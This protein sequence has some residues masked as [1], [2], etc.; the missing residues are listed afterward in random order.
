MGVQRA[1]G[2]RAARLLVQRR[3]APAP[4]K[5][6][7]KKAA[8][9]AKKAAGSPTEAAT[10]A[11][12]GAAAAP[13][14]PAAAGPATEGLAPASPAPAKAV[15]PVKKGGVP[16][17]KAAKKAGAAKKAAATMTAPK[18][19][20][21]KS[22]KSRSRGGGEGAKATAQSAEMAAVK[23]KARQRGQAMKSTPSGAA[24]AK[25]TQAA[26]QGPANE[27][28]A[29]AK[30]AQVGD[31]A[32]AP[33]GTFDKAAFIAAVEAAIRKSTPKNLEQADDFADS[34]KMNSVKGEV[35]GKVASGTDSAEGG[36]DDAA[37]AQPDQGRGTA[38][39]VTPEPPRK[40]AARPK[41]IGA[42][43][44]MPRKLPPAATDLSKPKK[45]TDAAMAGAGVT[46]EQLEQSNEP[47]FTGALEAKKEGEQHSATAPG[48]VRAA[49]QKTIA[50]AKAGASGDEKAALSSML[51]SRQGA[52]QAVTGLKSGGKGKDEAARK[53]VSDKIEAIY[54]A[55]QAETTAILDG[56]DA[57][58][59]AEF[60]S[61][62]AKAR[63][64][65]TRQHKTE[66]QAWKDKRY[67]GLRGKARWLKDKL[68]GVP[69]AAMRIFDRARETYLRHLRGTVA[70]IADIV[71]NE[72]TR[73]KKRIADGRQEIND[74]V[75]TLPENLQ[76]QG[77]E[78]AEGVQGR[79]DELSSQV[80]AKQGELVQ[81]VAKRFVDARGEIDAKV[82]E[83]KAAN[84]GL[85][86]R[87]KA[88]I[89]AV[90]ATIKKLKDALIGALKKGADAIGM[91]I[92]AP[93]KFLGNLI[94]AFKGGLKRFTDNI[95]KHLKNGLF[96]WLTGALGPA[97]IK[98]PE[99]FDLKGIIDLV[100]QVLGLTWANIKGRIVKKL[101]GGA[102]KAMGYIES[103]VGIV[104]QLIAQGP[105]ALWNLIASK[106]T[107]LWDMVV[108]KIKDFVLTK[109]IMQGIQWLIG[110][111]NPAAAFIKACKMI[112]DAVMWLWNNAARII[113]LINTIAGSIKKIASGAVDFASAAIEKTLA[114]LVPTLIGF[115]ASLLGLG[116]I[117]EKVKEIIAA[118]RRPINKVID[119]VVGKVVKMGKR[120]LRSP[121]GRKLS[122]AVKKGK[123]YVKKKI[124]QAKKAG[125]RAV[126]K[127]K[128]KIYGGDDSE[129]GKKKREETG[130][131]QGVA[132]LDKWAG[133]KV[134]TAMALPGLMAIKLKNGLSRLDL[135]PMG[136]F[137]GVEARVDRARRKSKAKQPVK[138]LEVG[139]YKDLASR[140][141]ADGMTPD[142][143]PSGA[144]V[145][146]AAERSARQK[147]IVLTEAMLDDIYNNH[148]ACVVVMSSDH[149]TL[150]R[151]YAGRNTQTLQALDLQDLRAAANADIDRYKS[152]WKADGVSPQKIGAVRRQ[153]HA[154]NEKL[155]LY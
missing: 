134:K 119:G 100:L 17:K 113:D 34:G 111:I 79:F 25:A 26:A 18:M 93:V 46:E 71:G 155:G 80:D 45:E 102:A 50:Q 7:V 145:K 10:K 77:A 14:G 33:T 98:L 139:T 30:A 29:G 40:A 23:A 27:K 52:D 63:A 82:K 144:A 124:D 44:A 20:E 130:A 105:I 108:G 154:L 88:A 59:D 21:G 140:S 72:L 47:Q 38:K 92:K 89:M 57:K 2:N 53:A 22:G 62:E 109:I 101:G 76:K 42:A 135:I 103:G 149:E 121:A 141:K 133:S 118:V 4:T 28:M 35:K 58:V 99:K 9:P 129:A 32:G 66:M 114:K 74:F 104:Q 41:P 24:E 8:A 120:F 73:A 31:M 78:L 16:P 6:A 83:L 49:E 123:A 137:W 36:V 56:I 61:G 1:A 125:Q 151:T 5:G 75:A 95:A 152:K 11:A 67:D 110:L 150:S 54:T 122:G 146:K 106:V 96:A 127:V 70:K 148:A 136:K 64:A 143:I 48:P 81:K 13:A 115:L 87:A 15:G 37:K 94:T 116:G 126:Q 90:I 97:G 112:I 19:G 138:H 51:S 117:G 91:I 128:K 84:S 65:F 43:K 39:Q 107:G 69:A 132:H 85:W 86:G 142:H 147:G 55:T 68:L 131:K 3:A 60:E 153:V 12:A